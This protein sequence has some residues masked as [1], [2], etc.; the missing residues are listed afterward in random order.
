MSER[1]GLKEFFN[2]HIAKSWDNADIWQLSFQSNWDTLL[3]KKY[4]NDTE[5][6][7]HLWKFKYTI[8]NS[9]IELFL[10]K[11]DYFTENNLIEFWII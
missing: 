4:D 11:Y 9:D 5:F 2:Q 10:T 3:Y 1:I 8:Q 6:Y 7:N